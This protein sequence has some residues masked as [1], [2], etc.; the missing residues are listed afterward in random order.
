M[1][2]P[3]ALTVLQVSSTAARS[4]RRHLLV[5]MPSGS[6]WMP[7]RP[8]GRVSG[9]AGIART[10]REGER[11]R[12]TLNHNGFNFDQPRHC[13]EAQPTTL[14][15][16]LCELRRVR[17]RQSGVARRRKQSR[18]FFAASG[19]LCFARNDERLIERY[20]PARART[21]TARNK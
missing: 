12:F 4:A 6:T 5:P 18:L 8:S 16:S 7:L 20:S 14:L 9:L 15:R 2:G 17:V 1:H 21:E 3:A 10:S 19:L 13:E 11:R